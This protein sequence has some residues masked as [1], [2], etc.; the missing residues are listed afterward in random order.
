M[1]KLRPVVKV[2]K[3]HS[4]GAIKL[5]PLASHAADANLPQL[6]DLFRYSFEGSPMGI[7]V[8]DRDFNVLLVNRK[9]EQL[10]AVAMPLVEKK[11]H[12][13]YHH[14]QEPCRVCP[15]RE[16]FATGC[17]QVEEIQYHAAGSAEGW[18][19]VYAF[20]LYR[21][22]G[23]LVGAVEYVN[24]I[25]LRKRAEQEKRQSEERLRLAMDNIPQSIFWKDRDL[26]YQGCNRQ[27]AQ[28]GG[29]SSPG[30]I[31]GKTAFD[32]PWSSHADFY[33]SDD[34]LVIELDTPKL[35]IEEP[36]IKADGSQVW[37]RTNKIPMHDD[38]GNV[39]GVIT[40][41]EDITERKR[42][43]QYILHTERLAAM[44]RL[45]AALAHEIN[46]PLHAIQNGLEL[47]L[48][49]P[50]DPQEQRNYLQAARLE[51][52]RL[53]ALTTRILDFARPPRFEPR[54]TD[55][56]EVVRHALAL[57]SKQLQNN[58][59]AVE[60]DLPEKF[61]QVLAS[62]DHLTQVFLNLII[63]AIEAMPF[64]GSLTVS[65]Q[66]RG[67][68]VMLRFSDTGSGIPPEVMNLIF[69]PFYSTKD[70][71]TG[72][73]LSVSY[74]IIRQLGGTISAQNSSLGAEFILTLP[75][76]GEQE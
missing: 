10:F 8:V 72:L 18:L 16:M 20:P 57:S 38:E 47:V 23:S 21:T 61:P 45:A 22:D 12:M 56:T 42:L 60:L 36:L 24:D 70:D 4:A 67:A 25:T 26:V 55:L 71:G 7:S 51:M 64:G 17:P 53:E 30:E 58:H 39:V 54:L 2:R 63:N 43:E 52:E 74:G 37:L 28:D 11:C 40:T 46:N 32:M 29:L 76:V 27:F 9:M 44:G 15:I 49:F 65:A 69:E 68:K 73:G 66:V 75:I 13:A 41:C 50:I 59:I 33:H 48:D 34:L 14:R 3:R 1:T 6:E 5:P 35:N 19:E 62:R 31:I